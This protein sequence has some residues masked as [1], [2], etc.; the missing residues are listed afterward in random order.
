MNRSQSLATT[1]RNSQEREAQPWRDT[2]P[3]KSRMLEFLQ[4]LHKKRQEKNCNTFV[5]KKGVQ[6]FFVKYFYMYTEKGKK[7]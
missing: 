5:G 2:L 6:V 1:I 4:I 7:R 3:W